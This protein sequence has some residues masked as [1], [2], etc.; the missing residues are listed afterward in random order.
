MSTLL[1]QSQQDAVS[2]TSS[3]L[4]IVAGAGTGKTTVITEKIAYL[5]KEGLAAPEEILALTFTDKT[6]L[7]LNERVDE[8]L[9]LGYVDLAISTFHTFCQ[10][11]LQEHGLDIGLPRDFKL[12]TETDAWLLVREHIYELG[13]N[14]YRPLGNPAKYIKDLLRHFSKCKDELIAP[15]DY[16]NYTEN[17]AHDSGDDNV[18][19][20]S[21]LTELANAYHAY[22]KIILDAGALDFGDL[23]Y[24]AVKLLRERPLVLA[25]VTKRYKY[26]LVDEFQD[27]NW[28]QYELVRLLS[29]E[30]Q[31][32][33]VGD[34]DQS[35]YAF[36]GASV[37][38]ILRFKDDFPTAKSI[39]LN[40]NYR[41]R[42]EILDA[43]YRVIQHNNPER[44][45][46]KLGINKKLIARKENEKEKKKKEKIVRHLHL[47]TLDDEVS[48]VV[49]EIISLKERDTD[50]V[51]DDFAILVRA[52]NHA[53]PFIR[54][55]EL[56]HIPY[57][58]LSASGLYRQPIILDAFSFLKVI[59]QTNDSAAIFRLLQLP[60][61]TLS[62]A[63]IHVFIAAA[64]KKSLSFFEI[65]S[66]IG[67]WG[68]SV[69]G[70]ETCVKLLGLIT[71]ALQSSKTAKPTTILY[72]FFEDSDYF[73]YLAHE[74]E[75]GNRDI[76]RQIYQLKQF[77]DIVAR[78][79]ETT[80]DPHVS[81]FV[82]Y[83]N[84]VIEA[85]DDGALYQPTDTPDSVNILSVHGAKGLEF[86]YVF[87]V[88]AV[89]E[90]F[91]TRRRGDG[92][93]MPIG[94][95]HERLPE[96]DYHIQEE[97]RL[98]YVAATRA[99]EKLYFTSA[100]NYG[101]VRAKKVSRFVVE[102]E[103]NQK[104]KDEKWKRSPTND[105]PTSSMDSASSP[106]AFHLSSSQPIT[107]PKS[108]L[109]YD[110]PK[111]FSF[112]QIK[113]YETCPYQYKLAHI[114]KIPTKGAASFSF[115]TTMHATLQ[116]FYTR[117]QE[118][119]RAQ[120]DSLFALSGEPIRK[121]KD[122]KMEDVCVPSLDE[123]L[124]MYDHHW[125][126]DWYESKRQREEYYQQGKD[127]L[128]KFYATEDGNWAVPVSLESWFKIKVG[129]YLIHGRIDRVDQMADGTL[130]IIDYKTGQAKEKLTLDD[131]DQL[132]IYQIAAETLPE[133]RH[134][135]KT[136]QL[137]FYYLND[138]IRT[139]FVGDLDDLDRVRNK[140][141]ATIDNIKAGKF[142]ATPSQ[143]I[144]GHCDFRDICEYRAK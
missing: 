120:Q 136:G 40:E 5:I 82:E 78:F 10:K 141:V 130:N 35:I 19:E 55:L 94:L 59:H 93:D 7:E 80:A 143:F 29:G 123:L 34:D 21:R 62:P 87:V 138:L 86:K 75:Q 57:E 31:L 118:M 72:S 60:C 24:Y 27:V 128:K 45:E 125:I 39:V 99:K 90:R 68:L 12:L 144:C 108:E 91:P 112:S 14:Y 92:I 135:G 50:S 104:M 129:E 102:A 96:G 44:L 41:S 15:V 4:L 140:V 3:P 22:N 81:H 134:V 30:G 139:S 66:H 23:I 11:L 85:G 53:E 116:D 13:L 54:A 49:K 107:Q 43:A 58:F 76:I 132:L 83:M 67:S 131:K 25:K 65:L 100:E 88:N 79:E 2:H 46:A 106:Q 1:N 126:P 98:F 33:V 69:E 111:A 8:K 142:T 42:Q 61:L 32:T 52:N 70:Q 9:D 89:E 17:A 74:E 26:I 18:D 110:L 127:I 119:N 95:I 6:A 122:G 84:T 73:K 28:A 113:S 97:R 124:K 37:S 115:G 101:G 16:L 114:L 20:K 64:K 71:T 103:I 117:V 47:T 36:R 109:I 137:T 63:D 38:N 77:F 51:W 105:E 133:Y 121:M 56:Q 48:A